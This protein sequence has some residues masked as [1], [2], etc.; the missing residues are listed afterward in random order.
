MIW[1]TRLNC[2]SNGT[3]GNR[4]GK[5]LRAARQ[6]HRSQQARQG[7]KDYQCFIGATILLGA[8]VAE[9]SL[10]LAVGYCSKK[11]SQGVVAQLLHWS[12][13]TPHW[14]PHYS[15]CCCS[16]GDGAAAAGT[17]TT[18][19]VALEHITCPSHL[20]DQ[21]YRTERCSGIAGMAAGAHN[22]RQHSN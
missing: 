6:R 5:Q 15:R 7:A 3:K 19:S 12:R 20:D 8:S 21:K 17:Q 14:S 18:D 10:G 11:D 22:E 16:V 13:T 4:T 2:T 1:R 9:H